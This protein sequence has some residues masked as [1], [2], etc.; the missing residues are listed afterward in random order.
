MTTSSHRPAS[1]ITSSARRRFGSAGAG[2]SLEL[3][4]RLRRA[5]GPHLLV[6][7]EIVPDELDA[8]GQQRVAALHA[9]LVEGELPVLVENLLGGEP[10]ARLVVMDPP[11]AI[12]GDGQAIDVALERDAPGR[13]ERQRNS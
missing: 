13:I 6:E 2:P 12:A 11:D 4:E 8:V 3:A 9:D 10:A 5:G 7:G 1:L